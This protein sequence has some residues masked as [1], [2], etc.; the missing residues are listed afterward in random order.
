MNSINQ[1]NGQVG[2]IKTVKAIRLR[3]NSDAM[4]FKSREEACAFVGCVMHKVSY[5]SNVLEFRFQF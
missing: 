4:Q 5:S 2:L 3:I 1:N